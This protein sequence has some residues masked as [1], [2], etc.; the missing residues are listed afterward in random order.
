MRII[1]GRPPNNKVRFRPSIGLAVARS[2]E[3]G[4]P[5]NWATILTELKTCKK[6][7]LVQFRLGWTQLESALG[8]YGTG[9]DWAKLEQWLDDLDF[10][11]VDGGPRDVS[12]FFNTKLFHQSWNIVPSYMLDGLDGLG[13]YG[14]GQ[15]NYPAVPGFVAGRVLRFD[16]AAVRTRF[17]ALAN[18]FARR[19]KDNPRVHI[20]GFPESSYGGTPD[21][22]VDEN[23]HFSG[24]TTCLTALKTAMP[25]TLVRAVFN[26]P[27]DIMATWFPAMV[28]ANAAH[29]VGGPNSAQS[30][31]G[32]GI[33]SPDK[34]EFQ[35]LKD[36]A[37]NVGVIMEFQRP[38]MEYDNLD[39]R[40]RP[41]STWLGTMTFANNGGNL[42][43]VGSGAHG[44]PID[45]T[46]DTVD[47][48]AGIQL[49]GAAGGFPA[50][51]LN[52]LSV[53][54]ANAI[55]VT[56]RSAW[57][58]GGALAAGALAFTHVASRGLTSPASVVRLAQAGGYPFGSGFTY[59][60]GITGNSTGYVPSKKQ[61]FDF[62]VQELSSNYVMVT[63]DQNVNTRSGLNNFDDFIQYINSMEG[64]HTFG[65][66]LV[67][68]RPTNIT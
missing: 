49:T 54:T 7:R 44:I 58:T 28:L 48:S 63:Y 39:N 30:E 15:N 37:G 12:I 50:G 60:P 1:K 42:Q 13:P 43:L 22:P 55:T 56:N 16:K 51:Y 3:T 66:G 53:D 26:H 19:Y 11:M 18:E 62:V 52:I 33:N 31:P 57:T 6:I 20:V 4:D 27:K 21:L 67:T 64:N 68:T 17:T 59:D 10:S 34:G 61:L 41:A 65:G 35:H 36:I 40:K 32:L 2:T 47:A 24:V 9:G 14:G 5:V 8:T 29:L 45:N 25:T 38:E 23:V 46:V